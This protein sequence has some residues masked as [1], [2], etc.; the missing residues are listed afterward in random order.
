M[1]NR[2][3]MRWLSGFAILFYLSLLCTP[4]AFAEHDTRVS[5]LADHQLQAV[6]V[7]IQQ[8]STTQTDDNHDKPAATSTA[9]VLTLFALIDSPALPSLSSFS[10]NWLLSVWRA[11]APPFSYC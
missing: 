7:S 9:A 11:R 1:L 6:P 8:Y 3:V 10:S 4:Q 2:G 5:P